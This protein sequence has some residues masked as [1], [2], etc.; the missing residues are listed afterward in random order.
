MH[1]HS[2]ICTLL[3]VE[4][5]QTPSEKILDPHHSVYIIPIIYTAT[6]GVFIVIPP[7]SLLHVNQ[8]V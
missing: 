2:E 1:V 5:L 3:L 7:I 6:Y 4:I 8:F